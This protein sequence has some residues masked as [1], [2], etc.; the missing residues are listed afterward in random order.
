MKKTQAKSSRKIWTL[1][2]TRY[3]KV[4]FWIDLE[5]LKASPCPHCFRQIVEKAA[6]EMIDE[7][8]ARKSRG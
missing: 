1:V 2:E 4:G 5:K 3:G 8:K 6:K 7:A